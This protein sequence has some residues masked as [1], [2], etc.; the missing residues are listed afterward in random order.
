MISS[1][2]SF[3]QPADPGMIHP[4]QVDP[5]ASLPTGADWF[6]YIGHVAQQ[7]QPG[8]SKPSIHRE[9]HELGELAIGVEV[10]VGRK[11]Q[12]SFSIDHRAKRHCFK[13]VNSRDGITITESGDKRLA[14]RNKGFSLLDW[15][16]QGH[17]TRLR[18]QS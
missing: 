6:P 17:S 9:G 8:S 11:N 5:N 13:I 14:D 1:I 10:V 18:Y 3:S 16:D 7:N 12:S 2:I 15:S 4:L